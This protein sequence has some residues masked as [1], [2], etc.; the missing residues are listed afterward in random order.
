MLLGASRVVAA[1]FSFFLAIPTMVAAS[2]YSLL[3]YKS[4]IT[5]P[6]IAILAVG[7]VASFIVALAVIKF[8]M[9]YIQKHNFKN[10]GVYRIVLGILVLFMFVIGIVH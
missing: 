5:D 2:A 6:E 8:F 3:K 9:N 1:E 4:H 7:F 10:F